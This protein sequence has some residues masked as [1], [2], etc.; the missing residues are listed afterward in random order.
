[1]SATAAE[2]LAAQGLI[3]TAPSAVQEAGSDHS[4]LSWNKVASGFPRWNRFL[5]C[6]VIL[7]DGRLLKSLK[8]DSSWHYLSPGSSG[9]VSVSTLCSSF[10]LTSPCALMPVEPGARWLF[11]FGSCT[12]NQWDATSA[13]PLLPKCQSGSR[14][15]S[16]LLDLCCWWLQHCCPQLSGLLWWTSLLRTETWEEKNKA[17][18]F[19]CL[20]KQVEVLCHL[21]CNYMKP[22]ELFGTDRKCDQNL[23]KRW[24]WK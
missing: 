19:V 21:F 13:P 20:L 12:A 6:T 1:M 8:Y 18:T 7:T 3:L 24:M 23:G 15:F 22:R 10:S 11:A 16:K 2:C 17:I 4:L 14:R 5:P 9:R